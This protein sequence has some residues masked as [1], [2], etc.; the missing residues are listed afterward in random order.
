M[1]KIQSIPEDTDVKKP[2]S[3]ETLLLQ[4]EKFDNLKHIFDK[5]D[6]DKS[7]FLDK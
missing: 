1:G 2:D 7:G 6:R 3:I 4:P 5:F